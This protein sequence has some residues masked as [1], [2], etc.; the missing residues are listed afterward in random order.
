MIKH[1]LPYFVSG[2]VINGFG[3]GSKELGIP[4]ANFP[5]DVVKNL[6][7]DL[8]TGIYFGWAKVNSGPV[9]KM[10]MSVGWNP[11][12]KNTEKTMETHIIHKFE[13]DFYGA[14]MKVCVLGYLRPEKNF[15]SV[16]ELIAEIQQDIAVA[17]AELAKEEFAKYKDSDFFSS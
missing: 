1:I 5:S 4:T 10:V 15:S 6:P 2:T 7:D 3:R 9:Y 16:D 8:E 11:F 17:E 14:T 13:Q 12:Y